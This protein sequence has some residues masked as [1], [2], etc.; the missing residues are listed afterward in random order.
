[1]VRLAVGAKTSDWRSL[2]LPAVFLVTS[3]RCFA[4]VLGQILPAQ[5]LDLQAGGAGEMAW[6]LQGQ[7]EYADG[8]SREKREEPGK[9]A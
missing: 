3:F 9:G 7:S 1:M 4:L 2:W 6:V 5:C 8:N